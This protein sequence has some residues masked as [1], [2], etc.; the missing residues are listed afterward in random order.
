MVDQ[1]LLL[2]ERSFINKADRRPATFSR[3]RISPVHCTTHSDRSPTMRVKGNKTIV[4]QNEERLRDNLTYFQGCEKDE[5]SWCDLEEDKEYKIAMNSF[6]SQNPVRRA[7]QVSK[8]KIETGKPD[9]ECFIDYLDKHPVVQ[10]Q[11]EGRIMIDYE[12]PDDDH[13]GSINLLISPF[14]FIF[15][16]FTNLF[17]K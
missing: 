16:I 4:G 8:I 14:I 1:T 5:D 10:N 9:N 15:A 3:N 12:L 2:D 13:S 11:W 6:L 17:W 7:M